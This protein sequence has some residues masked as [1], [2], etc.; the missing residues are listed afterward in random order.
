MVCSLLFQ[1]VVLK[2]STR[3]LFNRLFEFQ[4]RKSG[5]IFLVHAGSKTIEDCGGGVWQERRALESEIALA[6]VLGMGA[7]EDGV[8]LAKHHLASLEGIP[9]K[10]LELPLA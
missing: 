6:V 4:Q 7:V 1:R 3:I 9:R 5:P 10:L 8:A 2:D